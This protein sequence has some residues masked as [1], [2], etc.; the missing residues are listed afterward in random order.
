MDARLVGQSRRRRIYA[1]LVAIIVATAFLPLVAQ[2]AS[3]TSDPASGTGIT[4]EGCKITTLITLPNTDGKFIC[5]DA[6]YTTGNLGKGWNELD[7]VPGRLAIDSKV[8]QTF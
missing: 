1:A 6:A 3:A 4:L 2:R 7:L 8:A 5:P